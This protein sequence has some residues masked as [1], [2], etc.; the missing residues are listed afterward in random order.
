MPGD[1]DRTVHARLSTGLEVV[2]YDRE[3]RWFFEM[4]GHPRQRVT[5]K[6][7]VKTVRAAVA[8]KGDTIEIFEG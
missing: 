6:E 8:A 2:R 4:E 5:I 3:G 7:A 1:D